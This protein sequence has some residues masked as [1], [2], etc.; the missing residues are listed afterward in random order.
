M[1]SSGQPSFSEDALIERPAIDLFRTS[2]KYDYLNCWGDYGAGGSLGR[3]TTG[4]VVL[5]QRLRT[6]LKKLNPGAADRAIDGGVEELIRDR[7]AVTPVE[8]N[9]QIYDLLKEGVEVIYVDEAG[10][11]QRDRLKVIDWNDP[12]N[13]NFLLTSQLWVSGDLYKRRMDLVL[14]INGLPLVLIELKASHVNLKN[15]FRRNLRDYKSAV[16]QLFWYNAFIILSNGSYSRIG[17]ITSDWERFSEWKKI[18]REE[19]EGVISLETIL[20]GTCEPERLLD[21]IENFMV[22]EEVKGGRIKKLARNHQF[23]GVNNAIEAIRNIKENQG[24]LGVFWH[25]QGSGKSLSMVFFA[26]KVLR[27]VPGNFTFAVVTDRQELDQQIH[28]T[29]AAVGALTESEDQCHARSREHLKDLL[30]EDH[31]YVFTLIH[32]FGTKKGEDFPLLSDRSDVIVMTDEAHRSQYDVLA[33]NMRKAL[34]NAAFI[35][36]TGTPLMAGEEKTRE[37]FGD[38]VSVYDFQQSKEDGATVP[39]YYENRIPELELVNEA[40]NEQMNELL[41]EAMLDEDQERA[42]AR[43]FAREYHLITD[44][45]RLERVSEDLVYHFIGRG[46]QGKAMV[47]SIDKATAV[48]MYDKVQKYWKRELEALTQRLHGASEGE[49]Q[50]IED[51]IKSMTETDMAVVV[52]QGQGELEDFKDLSLD[53][54]THRK[55]MNTEDL[56][57]KFKDSDDPFRIVFVC[58]MWMTGFDVPSCNTIYLDK[59]MRNH[60]LMQTIARA[61]R[62]F[63]EKTSGL[64]VDYVGIFRDLRKALA[65]YGAGGAGGSGGTPVLSKDELIS[66]ARRA[67][68]E[69]ETLTAKL[70]IDLDAINA[71]DGFGR[72]A[73]LDEAVEKILVDDDTK[74]E[75]ISQSALVTR[76]Y[77]AILP[78]RASQEFASRKVLL[79][80]LVQ[81]IRALYPMPEVPDAMEQVEALLEESIAP[82]Y[83]ISSE[84]KVIDL[85]SID[86]EALKEEFDIGK[87]RTVAEKLKGL[88]S[89]KVREMVRLNN[90]RMDYRER[91]QQMIDDYNYGSKNIEELFDELKRFTAELTE[92][93]QR[94]MREG[95][96][97]EEL[98]V[99]DLLTKPDPE[100]TTSQEADVKKIVRELL[101]KLKTEKLVLDWRKRQQTRAGVRLAIEETLDDLPEVYDRPLYARK[102]D[103]VY[104]HV[105]DSYYG[106]GQSAYAEAS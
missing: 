61:N 90:T 105:Y 34:P 96:T 93:E 76:L 53:I 39:L 7:S 97:E 46:E 67:V 60:T 75:F 25:T 18:S 15:A 52:S 56:E 37:V 17:T 64:I 87:K 42:L 106:A 66:A 2:Y 89:A 65:I 88:L 38:Y 55:R 45:D 101:T 10:E 86:F 72:V 19:E 4:D 47:V 68:K 41:E 50:G 59:P 73:L 83:V 95:L 33:M 27:K 91:L 80:V 26:Q 85:S 13:N 8:A 11:Q 49:R 51:Q 43:E 32:K 104:Q 81:K 28:N 82:G 63:K 3:E 31:R 40:F 5:I 74:K 78:D 22:F 94:A 70:Q 84:S 69:A 16:P 21:L 54:A 30:R 98:V 14:F 99:F 79:E 1:Q 6:G 92:E 35:G 9:R 23:L 71:A 24:R 44:E 36:F 77:R 102:C 29:F 57:T 58:A 20:R 100:L 48:R 62:V 103:V 12:S